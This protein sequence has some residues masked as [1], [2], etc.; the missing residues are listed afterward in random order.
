MGVIFEFY[1]VPADVALDSLSAQAHEVG[2]P[3]NFLKSF[4]V[5][6]HSI[7]ELFDALSGTDLAGLM[8]DGSDASRAVRVPSARFAGLLAQTAAWASSPSQL[9][10]DAQIAVEDAVEEAGFRQQDL[11]VVVT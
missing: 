8:G 4:S 7:A 5:N 6:S 1:A 9:L 3:F 2:A 11:W 10:L